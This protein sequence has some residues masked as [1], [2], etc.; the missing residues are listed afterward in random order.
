MTQDKNHMSHGQARIADHDLCEI[1]LSM[2]K[3]LPW[4]TS[5][6]MELQYH[7]SVGSEMERIIYLDLVGVEYDE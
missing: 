2:R 5:L 7:R 4:V 1:D 6:L 3:R